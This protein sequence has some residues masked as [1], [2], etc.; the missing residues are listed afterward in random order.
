MT[1]PVAAQ[2]SA[3]VEIR[4]PHVGDIDRM[5]ALMGPY[6][7]V[8]DLLPR[9]PVDIL[10]EL[11]SFVIAVAADGAVVG[12]G[13]LKR[14]GVHLAEVRSLAVRDDYRTLG[15]GRAMVERLVARAHELGVIEIFA[16]T[17]RP[18]FFY[19]LGFQPASMERFPDKV[20]GDCT[21]CPRRNACDE[22]AVHR[23]LS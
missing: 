23:L 14:Y 18:T 4:A 20:W 11:P 13:A 19:R 10:L 16:L 12:I 9:T 2:A 5:L 1:Y 7:E 3:A 17:R 21:R 6:V 15:L 8:G 22:V